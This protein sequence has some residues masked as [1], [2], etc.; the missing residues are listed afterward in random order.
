MPRALRLPF[1]A[2]RTLPTPLYRQIYDGFR[3]AIVHGT[4]A[5]HER[6]PST[7]ALAQSLAVSRSTVVL[8]YELLLSEGYIRSGVGSGAYVAAGLPEETLVTSRAEKPS[9]QAS[10]R[11]R[12]LSRRGAL[13]A[14][15]TVTAI[16]APPA[17]RAFRPGLPDV[18]L[19][20]F[21][22]WARLAARR[23]RSAPRDL[24]GYS[25]PAGYLPLRKEIAAYLRASRGVTCEPE[26]VIVVAGTQ[27]ALDLAARLLLE[28]GDP[29][30]IEDPGYLGA[31]S[32]LGGSG[33]RLAPVPVDGDGLD[34][35]AGVSLCPDARLVYVTP[36]YQFPLGVTMSLPRRLGLLRW[37]TEMGAWIL[38]DDYDSEYRYVGRPL[39]ALQGIDT[40]GRVLYVGT[41]SK[42]LIPG[43]RLGYLVV[44][45]DLVDAFVAARATMDRHSPLL[46]QAILADFM[47]QGHFAHHVRRTRAIYAERQATLLETARSEL[48]GQV[49]MRPAPAG[50][51]LV[52]ELSEAGVDERALSRE[53]I[54]HG[55]VAPPL[56]A[57]GIRPARQRAVLLGYTTV[58]A[59]AIRSG[60]RALAVA[61]DVAKRNAKAAAG[62]SDPMS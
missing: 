3:H 2:D 49:R 39:A 25:D 56:S 46:D 41:F 43:L 5:P 61:F 29:V 11:R 22:T 54:R 13:L 24:L 59:A 10:G 32:A 23:W 53:A 14:E 52:G 4:L 19:F 44:P 42:V 1:G 60:V 27:Q 62:L 6:L 34:V 33:A 31:R 51:H 45:P 28:P 12:S 50:M 8:A 16:D 36:A 20:P 47:S 37:A 58:D 18:D 7:R 30:W 35:A 15:M 26:Q 17:V 55:V 57:Y 40:S 38:E 9:A 21:D 48:A